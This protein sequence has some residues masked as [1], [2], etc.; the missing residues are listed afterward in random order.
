MLSAL[1]GDG[2]ELSAL[3]RVIIE[4]TEGNPFFMEETVQ[5]MLD[6]GALVRAGA[7]VKLTKPVNALKIPPTVQG[8]LAARID[9]LPAGQKELLQTLAVI[10]RDFPL[11]LI[12]AVV[13]QSDE[14]LNHLLNDLQLGEFIYEQPAMGDSEYV[15]KHALTQEVAYNSLLIERRK[16]FHERAARALEEV[17][18]SKVDD[19]YA[20]LA[21]H[22]RRSGNTQKAVDYLQLAGGQAVQRSAYAEAISHLTSALELLQTLPATAERTQQELTLHAVLAPLLMAV[23]GYASPEAERSSFRARELCR[24][25]EEDTPQLL[26][27]LRAL[28]AF[29]A[30]TGELYTARELARQMLSITQSQSDAAVASDSHYM[31]AVSSF[32]IGDLASAR[33]HT[34]RALEIYHTTERRPLALHAMEDPR[35]GSLSFQAWT[36][37]YLGYPAQALQRVQEALALGQEL[38][39]PYNRAF[40]LAF[41]TWL[42]QLR[43]DREAVRERAETTIALSNEHGFPFWLSLGTVLSGWAM[44]AQGHHEESRTYT[45]R[46]RSPPADRGEKRAVVFFGF[47]GRSLPRGWAGGGGS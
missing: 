21:H 35:V 5:A 44:S 19:H 33:E 9:R 10:G 24:Q 7:A 1:V 15:F 2:E 42:H 31:L 22:Y 47:T 34:E 17:Y 4:K 43:G 45:T 27:V 30:N 32:F 3:K 40:T 12:R 28:V 25:V 39:S 26:P 41:A 37:W 13:P 46:H 16:A 29:Y 18:R 6:E 11:S 36:L 14:E 20:E 38:A 8:I 23:K